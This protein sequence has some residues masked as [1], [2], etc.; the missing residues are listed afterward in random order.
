[1]ARHSVTKYDYEDSDDVLRW[2][3][4]ML[5]R[6]VS[7]FADYY[8]DEPSSFNSTQELA[9]FPQF[10]YH[11]R[12]SDFLQTFGTS[13]GEAAHYRI[14]VALE[15]TMNTLVMIQPA[16]LQ[17][18]F[19]EGPPQP[20]PLD[21]CSLQ[22]DVILSTHDFFHVVVWSSEKTQAWSDTGYQNREDY[23]NLKTLIQAPSNDTQ[24][25]P[26]DRFP[27]PNFVQANAGGSWTRSYPR[28]RAKTCNSSTLKLQTAGG[29]ECLRRERQQRHNHDGRFARH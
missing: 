21:S 25:I 27:V 6:L 23:A 14:M 29:L 17:Y 2:I 15:S 12:R 4:G 22:P 10:M 13:P 9:I 3:D 11:L 7:R 8:K 26:A 5:I 20:V 24:Q 1:M 18:S 28:A 16:L 19:E